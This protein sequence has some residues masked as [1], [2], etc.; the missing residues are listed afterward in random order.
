MTQ[1]APCH[2]DA[3]NINQHGPDKRAVQRFACPE[4][5]GQ[6]DAELEQMS[7]ARR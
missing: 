6:F 1:P 7:R 3:Q 5:I 4:V 2:L